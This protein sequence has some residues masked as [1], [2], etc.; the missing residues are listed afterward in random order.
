ML[1][2][3]KTYKYINL[4]INNLYGGSQAEPLPTSDYQWH[5]NPEHF[6]NPEVIEKLKP[7]VS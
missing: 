3:N 5:P 1:Q 6:M 4:D 2:D 7:D